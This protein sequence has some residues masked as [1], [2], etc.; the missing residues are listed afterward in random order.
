MWGVH[1]PAGYGV[2]IE[3]A[4]V[5]CALC[6]VGALAFSL[7]HGSRRRLLLVAG[8]AT[9]AFG[10]RSLATQMVYGATAPL[11]WLTPGAQGG[12]IVGAVL[13]YGLETL[14]PRTRAAFGLAATLVGAVLVNVAPG[15]PYF[16]TTV[17]GL[18][19]GQLSNL[20]G[21]LRSV[22]VA[23]PMVV[24]VWFWRRTARGARGAG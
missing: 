9:V 3:A 23:W 19:A 11:A 22:S 10:L 18:N 21:L 16:D 1:A 14:G 5:I 8:I 17:A 6:A 7:V 12:L 20:H 13:L 4:S 24:I 15:D 2:A